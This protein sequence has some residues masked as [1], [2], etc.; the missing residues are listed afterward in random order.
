MT[1]A[2][3]MTRAVLKVQPNTSISDAIRLM[4]EQRVSG[5]PVIDQSGALVGVVTEGD[6]L[7]RV[8]VGTERRRPHWLEFIRGPGRQAEEYV[9]THGRK[10]SE[11]MTRDVVTVGEETPLDKIVELMEHKRIK[12]VFVVKDGRPVGVVSRSDLLRALAKALAETPPEGAGL[13]DAALRDQVVA[14]LRRQ[15][16][17]GRGHVTVLVTDSIA[18]LEGVVF[19]ERE[20]AGLR[21]A[22]EN[23][24]GIKEVQDNLDYFDPNYGLMTGL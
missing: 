20:Q 9:H 6:L 7:R 4:L 8:E 1:A 15:P 12:R 22:A 14:E 13:D 3:V 2:E 18:Y 24:P 10:I 19:D 5:V 11:V 21:V 23:V 16:W 17:S